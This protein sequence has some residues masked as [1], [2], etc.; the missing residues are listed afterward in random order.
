MIKI[1]RD[2]VQKSRERKSITKEFDDIIENI[3]TNDLN[4]TNIISSKSNENPVEVET[5]YDKSLEVDNPN[6][7]SE[8]EFINELDKKEYF[9]QMTEAY[10]HTDDENGLVFYE[11]KLLTNSVIQQKQD[12][13]KKTAN[14]HQNNVDLCDKSLNYS[15]QSQSTNFTV[16]LDYETDALRTELNN[17][18]EPPGPI[19]KTTKRLYIKKLIKYKRKLKLIKELQE[20]SQDQQISKYD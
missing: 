14:S 3:K 12:F 5:T 10:V 11:K 18:G 15:Q 8:V 6:L 2:K 4:Y 13:E 19:T 20:K 17:L 9:L 7:S 1:W 16:P